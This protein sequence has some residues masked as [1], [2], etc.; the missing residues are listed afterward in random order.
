MALTAVQ[1][2]NAKP[3]EKPLKISD[4]GGLY[5]LI[6][7]NGSKYW[8]MGY[9]FNSIQKTLAL[10]VFPSVSLLKAREMREEAR[11]LLAAGT[12]PSANKKAIKSAK[13]TSNSNSFEAI[14]REWHASRLQTWAPANSKKVIQALERDIFDWLG[15]RPI[16][17]ITSPELLECARR[18]EERGAIE[19]ARRVLLTC[20]QVFRYAVATG[21][22]DRDP[23]PD[24][25][26][27]LK[28]AKS[29]HFATMLDPKAIGALLRAIESYQGSFITRQALRLAPLV[30]VRPGNLRSAEWIEI[31]LGK[32]EWNIPA[33]KMKMKEPLLV[34]LSTQAV[35]ILGEIH[36]LTG[37]GKY[38]FP[39][40]HTNI[41]PMSENTINFAFRR[42]GFSKE[43]ISCHG[44]RAMARTLLDEVL[45]VRSD[46]IEHQLAHAVRD[47]NGRAYNRTCHIVARREMMQQ[48]SAYL[49]SLRLSEV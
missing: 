39:C 8:R 45:G 1:I 10:G 27:A 41:R 15:K 3:A 14:A 35:A 2:K 40:E 30:F 47:P 37:R 21:R 4:G 13:D 36:A 5:L 42:M 43:E 44:F 33:E 46:F 49:D 34:P 31:D 11:K 20:G 9:R 24:L 23:V 22:C 19:S 12:D 28:P 16:T 17:S 25:R 48:W 6:N 38:V 18:M 26:G 7:P 29:T 32:A